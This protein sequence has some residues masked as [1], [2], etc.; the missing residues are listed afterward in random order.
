MKQRIRIFTLFISHYFT[1]MR[2]KWKSLPLLLLF[3]FFMI[4][5][6]AIG[7]ISFFIQPEDHPL[8]VGLVDHDQSEET[9]MIITAFIEG[10]DIG[11]FIQV[12]TVDEKEAEGMIDNEQLSA[13]IEFPQ[14]FTS[15][16]YNGNQ[17]HIPVVGSVKHPLQSQLIYEFVQSV[18]RHI[19]TAQASILTIYSYAKELPMDNE[20]QTNMLF[21]E[22]KEFFFYALNKDDILEQ[23]E[24][25]NKATFSPT[26]YFSIAILFFT[27]IV[28]SFLFYMTLYKET[29][30][31]LLRRMSVYGVHSSQLISSRL[32]VAYICS[33][34]ST[35][36]L[37]F[38]LRPMMFEHMD[39]T[40]SGHVVLLLALSIGIFMIGLGI[41]DQLSSS[42][43]FTLTI[44]LIYVSICIIGSGAILPRMY[45][46]M[47]V[48]PILDQFFST[49]T[50]D[51]L[52][53]MMIFDG[54]LISY[55]LL[56]ISLGIGLILYG[57]ISLW[58]A[59][60]HR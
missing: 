41:I 27:S 19:Q 12:I 47:S 22:F 31:N 14:G 24:M 51:T 6:I 53:H 49:Y 32:L 20:Q 4:G 7:L 13:Y 18:M 9:D 21:E 5:F 46:P 54:V 15:D 26:M 23:T 45:F 34:I 29:S 50:F 33:F 3:P 55:Q 40:S 16:L 11:D 10:T 56:W 2:R 1:H 17:V 44:Q 52:V 38:L 60:V 59:R 25:Q 35:T 58:K 30:S 28:W 39:L 8:R 42:M 37:F 43:Q 48:Q 57:I 36:G